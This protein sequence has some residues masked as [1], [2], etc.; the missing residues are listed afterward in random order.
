MTAEQYRTFREHGEEDYAKQIAESGSM[1]WEDALEKSAQDFDD[2]LPHGLDTADQHLRT[3][4]D[5]DEPVGLLWLR[6]RTSAQE[7]SAFVNDLMVYE[8]RRRQGYGRAIMT[9]G[10]E[11]ARRL[12]AT[13]I[14]LTVW[15]GNAGA[16]ALYEQLGYEVTSL[17]MHKR[18]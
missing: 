7:R 4:Y 8:D 6:V 3:A 10:E 12:G 16:R 13:S 11:L 9:A 14:G 5:G 15:G 17:Q 2:Q 1:S 18:L